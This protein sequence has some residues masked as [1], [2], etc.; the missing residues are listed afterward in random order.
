MS[1]LWK[2]L[3]EAVTKDDLF[4]RITLVVFGFAAL[5]LGFLAVRE[6]VHSTESWGW[7]L[8]LWCVGALFHSWGATVVLAAFTPPL[9]RW[10][11]FA[12][13]VYPN[14]AALDDFAVFLIVVL[15]PAEGTG[16]RSP[17]AHPLTPRTLLYMFDS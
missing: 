16:V 6:A 14:P 17:I 7:L 13:K 9:S 1:A 4:I 15:I 12:E 8:A 10:S 3:V 2:S 5:V 11:K